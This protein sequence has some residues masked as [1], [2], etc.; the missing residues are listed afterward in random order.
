MTPFR[1]TFAARTSGVLLLGGLVVLSFGCDRSP[2]DRTERGMD[3]GEQRQAARDFR[4]A[5]NAYEQALDGTA[6]TSEAHFR[7]GLIY[8]DKLNDEVGAVHHFRRYMELS[9]NGLH[10]KE[11]QASLARLELTLATKLAGGTLITHAEAVKLKTDNADLR[12]QLAARDNPA[13]A[14]NGTAPT[15]AAGGKKPAPGS[16]SYVVQP[17][18]TLASI[19]RKFY[20][21]KA[22]A[23]DI[24]DANLNSVPSPTKL[25]PGMTLIIP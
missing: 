16:K 2:F 17:G 24:Q 9:P 21:N 20:K 14:A 8:A 7:L 5:V 19:A 4:G 3:Q 11:A 12:K 15:S 10:V 1:T 13:L 23:K 6:K 22:R 18:D 25:K